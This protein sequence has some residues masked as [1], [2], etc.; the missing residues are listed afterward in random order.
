MDTK[1]LEALR[2]MQAWVRE[3]VG[4]CQDMALLDL[5]YKLL[6]MQ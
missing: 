2:Q 4:T 6:A 3:L 5:I 1:Q